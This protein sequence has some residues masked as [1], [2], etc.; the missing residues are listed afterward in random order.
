MKKII[1]AL[2][3]LFLLTA[4]SAE[5]GQEELLDEESA[6]EIGPCKII[7][8]WEMTVPGPDGTLAVTGVFNADGT[9]EG[10]FCVG[11]ADSIAATITS[12]DINKTVPLNTGHFGLYEMN[13]D[14]VEVKAENMSSTFTG[15][16]T[17]DTTVTGT[18]VNHDRGTGGSFTA[19][20]ISD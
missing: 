5:P 9:D 20:K 12:P 11:T 7:G 16:F 14:N 6:E 13:G 10:D 8:T 18:W 3:S 1:V 15:T 17:S 2:F 19:E 4:C